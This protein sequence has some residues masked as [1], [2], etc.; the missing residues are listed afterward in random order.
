[1]RKLKQEELAT[2]ANIEV[3]TIKRIENNKVVSSIYMYN[4]IIA[5]LNI[6]SDLIYD[7]YFRFINSNYS[8]VIKGLRQEKKLTQKQFGDLLGVHL[9][10]IL[11][12][13]KGIM[14]PSINHYENLK[15]LQKN[16]LHLLT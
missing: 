8:Y 4:K 1:M 14:T 2:L 10:T 15:I 3:S 16:L 13:E 11:R 12:W 6:H 9:K 5:A 7:E